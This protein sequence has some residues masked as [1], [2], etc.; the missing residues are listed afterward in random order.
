MEKKKNY[1][2]PAPVTLTLVSSAEVCFAQLV[3]EQTD[4]AGDCVKAKQQHS[5]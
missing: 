5:K 3:W 4:I 2:A 1:N